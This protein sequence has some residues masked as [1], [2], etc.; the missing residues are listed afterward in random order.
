[1]EQPLTERL[2]DE[3]FAALSGCSVCAA[4]SSDA[5][6]NPGT[7]VVPDLCDAGSWERQTTR[8]DEEYEVALDADPDLEDRME[9]PVSN[10]TL[11]LSSVI[12]MCVAAPDVPRGH[13]VN[14]DKVR[15]ALPS[16]AWVRVLKLIK[17]EVEQR[18]FAPDS[19]VREAMQPFYAAV[20]DGRGLDAAD[21]FNIAV[22]YQVLLKTPL[23]QKVRLILEPLEYRDEED[24][25]G[26]DDCTKEYQEV[27]I[28]P[29]PRQ[30]AR[31]RHSF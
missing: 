1:M 31:R 20:A 19:F 12:S 24:M 10:Y 18:V 16:L 4:A 27:A 2:T 21:A 14:F 22:F 13:S 15:R 29:M 3:E 6:A 5:A 17:R 7:V 11:P 25:A 26:D 23:P 9:I 28:E 8:A 30:L